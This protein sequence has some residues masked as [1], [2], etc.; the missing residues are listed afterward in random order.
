MARY[1]PSLL[2]A[3][4]RVTPPQLWVTPHGARLFTNEAVTALQEEQRAKQCAITQELT[5]T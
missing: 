4:M 2:L 3:H 5:M 1:L